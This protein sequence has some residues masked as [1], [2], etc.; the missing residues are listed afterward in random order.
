V[1]GFSNVGCILGLNL[2]GNNLILE[3]NHYD[4]QMC[5]EED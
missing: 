4:T 1:V 5:G 2:G 3:N